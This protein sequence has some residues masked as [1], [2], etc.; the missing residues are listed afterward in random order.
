M[1]GDFAGVKVLVTGATSGIGAACARLFTARGAEVML[2]GRDSGRGATIVKA[3]EQAGGVADFT[4]G[5]VRAVA[6]CEAIVQAPAI[7]S[8]ASTS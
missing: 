4:A 8:V 7:A 2:T 3:I 1:S 5:D 6:S